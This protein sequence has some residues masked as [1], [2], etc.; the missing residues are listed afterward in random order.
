MNKLREIIY[1]RKI[2]AKST[3]K[4]KNRINNPIKQIPIPSHHDVIHTLIHEL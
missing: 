1:E 2:R 4:L 3:K